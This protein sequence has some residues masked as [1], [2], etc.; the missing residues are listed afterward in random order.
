MQILNSYNF[1]FKFIQFIFFVFTHLDLFNHLFIYQ[2]SKAG[3]FNVRETE[4]ERLRRQNRDDLAPFFD[5]NSQM[6]HDDKEAL[7]KFH[8]IRNRNDLKNLL[9]KFK[10]EHGHKRDP[11]HEKHTGA[12]SAIHDIDIDE[13]VRKFKV[14][15]A[16]EETQK[17]FNKSSSN[18]L[19]KQSHPQARSAD[20]RHPKKIIEPGQ[21]RKNKNFDNSD[22][23][24]TERDRPTSDSDGNNE[25][26]DNRN[27][28]DLQKIRDEFSPKS[29][30]G[31][32]NSRSPLRTNLWSKITGN[33]KYSQRN[34]SRAQHK[35]DENS[36]DKEHDRVENSVGSHLK[37][38]LSKLKNNANAIIKKKDDSEDEDEYFSHVKRQLENE[39]YK[40]T[41]LSSSSK[42]RS[43]KSSPLHEW[44]KVSNYMQHYGDFRK[45]FENRNVSP[46]HANDRNS[47]SPVERVKKF[48]N[49]FSL[50]SKNVKEPYDGRFEQR[51][52]TEYEK[53]MI[54][55]A[56]KRQ[57]GTS[58]AMSP[59][60]HEGQA[61]TEGRA[62][63]SWESRPSDKQKERIDE[64][65]SNQ[66]NNR[67]AKSAPNQ[68]PQANV[69]FSSNTVH[70]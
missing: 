38:F 58:G 57:Y 3:G 31:K 35:F 63:F 42:K 60:K 62:P 23:Q 18:Y 19:K 15:D 50:N 10:T 13:M 66:E 9:E 68:R 2:R 6:I 36:A 48:F 55:E 41:H 67:S 7:E 28:S 64:M 27:K 53:T 65:N 34:L 40:K 16:L 46:N 5:E 33:D 30:Q 8:N 17:S 20:K 59:L 70:I 49:S 61:R 37:A 54:N 26:K 56:Y 51:E 1:W 25:N 24:N 14:Q 43:E 47:K 29:W 45:Q 21:S 39:K 32:A 22:E 4:N 52:Y 11:I 44:S 69:A 12:E